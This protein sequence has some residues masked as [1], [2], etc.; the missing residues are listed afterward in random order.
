MPRSIASRPPHSLKLQLLFGGQFVF[1]PDG[2]FHVQA[3]NLPFV[4][5][6]FVEL[7]QCLLLVYRALFHG[8]LQFFHRVLKLPLQLVEAGGGLVDLRHA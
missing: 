4:L 1:E 7:R 5:E 3:L 8:C 6:H 2:Q